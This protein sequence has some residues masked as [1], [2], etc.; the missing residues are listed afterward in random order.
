[1]KN[2]FTFLSTS[3][4]VLFVMLITIPLHAAGLMK[5]DSIVM[6]AGYA[7][8]VFYSMANGVVQTS[9]RATWDIAFRTMKMSSS[10]LTNDGSGV[11]LYT[12]PKADTSGWATMDTA[13][14]SSWKPMFNDPTDWE[15]G[16]FSRNASG[17][18]DYGWCKYNDVTH[19]LTG[20]SLFVI[21]LR[22]GS[23]KKLWM[24]KKLS[25]ANIYIF[26]YANLDGSS[27][28][29]VS[30][31]LNSVMTTDFSGFSLQ[32]NSRV[33]FEPAKTSWDILFTKYMSIQ[34][35]GTPYLVTGV[36][37]NE[38][39]KTKKFYPVSLDYSDFG[40]GTWDSTRSSIG[41]DWKVFD[42]QSF[43]FK[44]VDSTVYF[45]KPVQG[46]IYKL[47]FTHFAGTSTGLVKFDLVKA[48]GVGISETFAGNIQ[49][50]VFPNPAT[51]RINLYMTGI[52]GEDLTIT[53]TDLSG[54]Q[55]R[56][57][58]PGRMADGPNAYSMDVT[59]VQPGIYFVTVSTA[60]TKTVTKV[61]IIR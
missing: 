36:L 58:R 48:A 47:I 50:T 1:M 13:G 17:H 27:E 29:N 53:L 10:I 38:S 52:T 55:L 15:N 19:N 2:T 18:P 5:S 30:E 49:S 40:A 59:G 21:K 26:R 11:V 24:M 32:T 46:D 34:S 43:T 60:A 45:V 61:M 9:P 44:V 41:W 16:A 51:S 4:V 25:A 33:A 22:D 37:S 20:D 23:F 56:A 12:Y 14:L 31:D 28:Q 6:S 3:L 54:R 39:V 8:D 7:N 57:D 42:M 35:N